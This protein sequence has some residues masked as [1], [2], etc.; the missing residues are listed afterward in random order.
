MRSSKTS[1]DRFGLGSRR[2]YPRQFN[3][4]DAVDRFSLQD[5]EKA[6]ITY[7][8]TTPIISFF[9]SFCCCTKIF[10]SFSKCV[11]IS[12]FNLRNT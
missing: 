8:E 11:V 6:Y 10:C 3:Q 12:E 1:F 2:G 7:G 9:Q 4:P 5:K